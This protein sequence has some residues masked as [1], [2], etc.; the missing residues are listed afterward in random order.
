V[1]DRQKI[2][3]NIHLVVNGDSVDFLSE[4]EFQVFTSDDQDATK[5]LRK[6]IERTEPVWD[7][8]RSVME[9]GT[10]VT[11]TLGNHDLELSLPGP[12]RLLRKTMGLGNFDFFYD[13]QALRIGDVLIEHGNR[14]D[15]WN[16]VSHEN[17]RDV[18]VQISRGLE[19]PEFRSPAGSHMVI[20]VMNGFKNQYSFINLLKPENEAAI[21]LLAVLDPG[22]FEKF[23]RI[24]QFAARATESRRERDEIAADVSGE[25]S[26]LHADDRQALDV[27]R[28][29]V[30]PGDPDQVGFASVTDI[31]SGLKANAMEWY[32]RQQIEKLYKAF[33]Y[34]LGPQLTAFDTGQEGKAYSDAA[35]ASARAGF[36]VIVYGHTHLAKKVQ[37]NG[38]TYLNTGTW[39][40]LM[41]VPSSILLNELVDEAKRDLD[42]FVRDFENNR[43]SN[44]IGRLPTF[45]Q[46]EVDKCRAVSA[47]VYL[48]EGADKIAKMPEGR[49]CRL[50]IKPESGADPAGA[51]T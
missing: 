18:R 12:R 7:E 35:A 41:C 11:F 44:W 6:I 25:V 48:F 28:D 16:S 24:A 51:R 5:K 45:A 33:R 30:F 9:A 19:P 39:A 50:L 47:D 29:L 32:R 3:K 10:Q 40:D 14:Y 36:K 43:L 20:D 4:P 31:L 15:R 27:A 49:L 46:I 21:P 17:L 34:W 2:D 8:F 23:P 38:A 37:I 1:A 22:A 42:V 13:N 26:E